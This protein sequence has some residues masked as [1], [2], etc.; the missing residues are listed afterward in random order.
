[1]MTCK[2]F[3]DQLL[4]YTEDDLNAE[5]RRLCRQ[6]ADLCRDC[7]DYLNEYEATAKL[8]RDAFEGDAEAPDLPEELVQS[9]L[10]AVE[11]TP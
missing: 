2:D 1:M 8:C 4:D 6:H 5:A 7:A 10:Q 3:I 11:A 9:I